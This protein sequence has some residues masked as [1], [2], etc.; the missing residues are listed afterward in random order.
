[1]SPTTPSKTKPPVESG[2][3]SKTFAY[4]AAFITLGIIGVALGPTLPDLAENTQASI[5]QI[6]FL[7]AAR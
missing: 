1:M 3:L 6:S 5:S 2:K 4:Y 7:F